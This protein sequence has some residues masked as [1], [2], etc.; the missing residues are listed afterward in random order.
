MTESPR[1]TISPTIVV[2]EILTT[3]A[4]RL[5]PLIA[6]HLQDR[7]RGREWTSLLTELDHSRGR[8][9]RAYRRTDL[10]S[11]LRMLTERLGRLGYPFDDQL[12]QVSTVASEL[13]II[14]NRWAHNDILTDLDAIRTAD[15][16]ARLLNSLGDAAAAHSLEEERT[17]LITAYV[18]AHGEAS[19]ASVSLPDLPTVQ[20]ADQ[21]MKRKD[22]YTAPSADDLHRTDS[23]GADPTNTPTIGNGRYEFEGWEVVPAG[24]SEVIDGLP[25]KAAK[26]QVRGVAAEIA[27]FEGPISI[28][29]LITLTTRSFGKSRC[30]PKKKQQIARQLRQIG[31]AVD[32]DDFVWPSDM[33]P[34]SWREFRPNDSMADRPFD[35][36]SPV[37][38]ANAWRIIVAR[39]PSASDGETRRAVLQAFGRK[40]MTSAITAHLDRAQQH[41]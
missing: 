37:E 20:P 24:G 3:L 30:G 11:Q 35:D 6:G 19:R 40:R 1:A 22:D 15:F 31:L 18:A 38:I 10:Q 13:R 28:E 2:S 17:R 41:L 12:R 9:T 21:P 27:E 36:I 14:R 34:E 4:R 33:T 8:A 26:M 25:K 5:D 23:K 39:T 29:R 16:G 7:L 32:E